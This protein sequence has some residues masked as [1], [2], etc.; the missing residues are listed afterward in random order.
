[1]TKQRYR[2]LMKNQ[3]LQLTEDEVKEG[4]LFCPEFDELLMNRNECDLGKSCLCKKFG[5]RE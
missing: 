1:M 2:E 5:N 3:E 4:W